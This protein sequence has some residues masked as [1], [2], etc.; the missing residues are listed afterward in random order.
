MAPFRT[1][2]RAIRYKSGGEVR[3]LPSLR[4]AA[5]ARC[6]AHLSQHVAS[7]GELYDGEMAGYVL[8]VWNAKGES[9]VSRQTS[10]A[11]PIGAALLPTFAAERIRR[12]QCDKDAEDTVRRIFDLPDEKA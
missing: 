11:D 1:R 5:H 2:I 12:A 6:M 3:L 7:F 9:S 4:E 10:P 8:I